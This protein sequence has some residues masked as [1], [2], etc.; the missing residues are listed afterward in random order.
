MEPSVKKIKQP[1]QQ[2]IK[3]RQTQ[4][5]KRATQLIEVLERLR[6]QILCGSSTKDRLRNVRPIKVYGERLAREAKALVE[7]KEFG[8]LADSDTKPHK[9]ART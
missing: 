1:K 9:P 5:L 3:A 6:T 8:S 4:I 7:S 2:P